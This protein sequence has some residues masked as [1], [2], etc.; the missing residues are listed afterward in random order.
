LGVAP[1]VHYLALRLNA[2][3]RNVIET[4]VPFADIAAATGFN[5]SSAFARSYRA[6]FGESASDTR[7]RLRGTV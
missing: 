2:A 1:H 4:K 5:S 3:R 6:H 7:K